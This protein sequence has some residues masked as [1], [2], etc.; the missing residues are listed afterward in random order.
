LLGDK[1]EAE[2][3]ARDA[4]KADEAQVQ[5]LANL[6]WVLWS[7]E[8]HDEARQTFE[9]LRQLSAS[10]DLDV[11]VF[12]RLQP[13]VEDLRL[14][15][16]WRVAAAPAPD[17]GVRPELASLGPFR[18]RPSPAPGWSLSD[19]TGKQV[20]LMEYH[21]RPVL[22]VF[23]LGSGCAHCI[24]QLNVFGPMAG[25]FRE[26]GVEIIAVSTDSADGL[27]RT[28]QKAKDGAGFP[29]PIV[30]D[31]SLATFKAY[32]AFDDFEKIPLHGTYLVDG[33]GLIRWQ[34]IGYEP[35]RD[36]KWLLGETKRLL[37]IPAANQTTAARAKLAPAEAR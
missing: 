31:D 18:W 2:K 8:K 16:D 5:P 12:R 1:A 24:E 28:F 11:P 19:S 3:Q 26:A 22:V 21:G 29:F 7:C 6:A 27:H 14:P 25:E 9:K 34:D 13:I 37:S 17:A 35:F 36:A 32:R 23:Y 33:A 15:A 4:S 10:V 20:S 30:A